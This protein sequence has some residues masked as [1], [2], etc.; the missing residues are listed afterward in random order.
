MAKTVRMSFSLDA[1]KEAD[2][3]R[4]L[5]LEVNVSSVVR[6]ALRAYYS[7]PTLADIE[8][9]LDEVIETLRGVQVIDASGSGSSPAESEPAAAR[10]GLDAMLDKYRA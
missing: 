3:L 2:L 1:I 5:E 4:R 7:Q 9:K 6:E 8:R 10:K